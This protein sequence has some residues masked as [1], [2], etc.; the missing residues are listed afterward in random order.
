[1]EPHK[2]SSGQT[3]GSQKPIPVLFYSFIGVL[4]LLCIGLFAYTVDPKLDLNGDNVTYIRLAHA[5]ADGQGYSNVSADGNITPASHFPPGYSAVLSVLIRLGL[6]SLIAFKMLN[7][8]FLLLSVLGLF[9]MTR[10]LTGQTYLAFSIAVL[11]MFSPSLLHFTGIVMSEMSYMFATVAA[12]FMLYIYD[13]KSR[14]KPVAFYRSP[15]FYLAVLFAASAYYIRTVGASVMFAVVVFYLFRKEWLAAAASAAGCFLCL[16]PWS[17]RNTAYGIE[18][19]YLGTVMT[20]NPWRPEEGS[21]S[22]VGEMVEKMWVNINDTVIQGFKGLLFPFGDWATTGF[23]A[24]FFGLLV[25]AVVFYGVWQMGRMRWA[26]LA[27]LLANIGLFA[28]WHGGNG[29]RYVTPVIPYL[30]VFFFVGVWAA[31]CWILKR[32][33]S[34][35]KSDSLAGLLPLLLV[36]PMSGPVRERHA[37][38][39]Q[40]YPP[41]YAHYFHLAQMV[42]NSVEKGTV[43]CCRKPEFFVHFAPDVVTTNYLYDLDPAAVVR[44]LIDKKVDY[45]V[46]EQLGYGS[47]VRYLYPAVRA[48]PDLFPVVYVSP[49]PE[50]YLLKFNREAAIQKLIASDVE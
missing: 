42:Q 6:D 27:F 7:V 35:F 34:G 32:R 3:G 44:D 30:F 19:R 4:T 9:I 5:L 21:I 14:T 50:T 37:T 49:A 11:T 43:V 8:L 40:P 26:M 39:K 24:W 46:L 31:V 25:V 17:L 33:S 23:G 48:Y 28:L 2:L 13:G 20:V 41:A 22:T 10:R 15:Y 38:V 12:L 18:S 45:V 16:L 36:L 1:M 29:T 47:T